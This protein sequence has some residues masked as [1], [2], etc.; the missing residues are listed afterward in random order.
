ML[1]KI[2]SWFKKPKAEVVEMAV[3]AG[4]T[5]QVLDPIKMP[6]IRQASIFLAE[7]ERDWGMTKEDLLNYDD[8]L[9]KITEFPKGWASE[10]DL[11]SQITEKLKKLYN[12]IDTRRLLIQEDFQ[13]KPFLKAACNMIIIDDEDV[14]KI[15]PVYIQK[16]LSLCESNEEVMLFF[17]RIIR[18]F[19]QSTVTIFDISKMWEFYPEKH[20]ILTEKKVLKVI[21]TNIFSHGHS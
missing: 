12:L 4:H 6:K 20:L 14:N 5:F 18:A 13:Y 11:V 8:L 16:K 7:Y 17:L 10:Q 2:K 19:Q 15:D 1:N 9:C 21:H 3:I